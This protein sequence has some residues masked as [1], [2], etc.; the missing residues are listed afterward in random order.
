MPAST[1]AARFQRAS[2]G[3]ILPPDKHVRQFGVPPL[4]S[5]KPSAFAARQN[6]APARRRPAQPGS[7]G[8][9]VKKQPLPQKRGTPNND[10]VRLRPNVTRE[11]K[12]F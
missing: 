2:D 1:V 8:R 10:S 9:A 5:A 7:G 4:A 6:A 12:Y 11:E 3:G